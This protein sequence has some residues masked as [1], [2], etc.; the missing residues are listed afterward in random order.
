MD[1]DKKLQSILD[2]VRFSSGLSKVASDNSNKAGEKYSPASNL[3]TNLTYLAELVKE[4]SDE[5]TYKDVS[6]FFANRFNKE[7]TDDMVKSAASLSDEDSH[8]LEKVSQIVCAAVG[9]EILK[10]KLS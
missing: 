8:K 1:L 6:D 5:I 9:L 3:S 4:S 10:R 7:L 2:S